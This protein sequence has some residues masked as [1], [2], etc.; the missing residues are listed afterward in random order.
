MEASRWEFPRI[1]D[2]LVRTR[3]W[4]ETRSVLSSVEMGRYTGAR[5]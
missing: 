4:S 5:V 3:R 1:R 2:L